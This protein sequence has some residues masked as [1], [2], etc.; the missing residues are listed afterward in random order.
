[1]GQAHQDRH[2]TGPAG[3]ATIA[4][5]ISRSAAS[6]GIVAS[7]TV[8][9]GWVLDVPVLRSILPGE[10][11]MVA[12]TALALLLLS[13]ALLLSTRRR[14][15]AA[16]RTTGRWLAGLASVVSFG[17]SLQYVGPHGFRLDDWTQ[18]LVSGPLGPD[19]GMSFATA[20]CVLRAAAGLLLQDAGRPSLRRVGLAATLAALV[21]ATVGVLG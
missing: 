13:S 3:P 7:L 12:L 18:R 11:P 6:L 2:A 14:R 17:G 1:M 5:L 19:R 9:L 15:H 16:S 21:A 4:K 8:M 10:A 20:A